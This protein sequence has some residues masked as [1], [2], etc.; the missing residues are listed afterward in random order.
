MTMI[1]AMSKGGLEPRSWPG[2]TPTSPQNSWQSEP[3]CGQNL[4]VI[5][6]APAMKHLTWYQIWIF[7]IPSTLVKQLPGHDM[8]RGLG[9][10]CGLT[11]QNLLEICNPTTQKHYP[12]NKKKKK[13]CGLTAGRTKK[14]R[15]NCRMVVRQGRSLDKGRG[16]MRVSYF[17]NVSFLVVRPSCKVS[18]K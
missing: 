4:N 5:P 16:V 1:N 2:G 13:N 6:Q 18:L 12:K 15:S 3:N 9:K 11:T 17:V 8:T 14:L 10:K 7:W